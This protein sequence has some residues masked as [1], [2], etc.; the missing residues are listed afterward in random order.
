[1]ST[2]TILLWLDVHA[3][4][5]LSLFLVLFLRRPSLALPCLCLSLPIPLLGPALSL[6]MLLP[7]RREGYAMTAEESIQRLDG[8]HGEYT[9]V[10]RLMNTV[11]AS[12]ALTLSA[13]GDRRAYLL[14]LLRQREIEPL[15][16][17]LHRALH[18]AD[19]ESA[20][21]AASAI[22]ELQRL[23]YNAMEQAAKAYVPGPDGSWEAARRYGEAIA[24]YLENSEVGNLENVLSRRQYESVMVDLLQSHA[25]ACTGEDYA[26]MARFLLSERRFEEALAYTQAYVRAF[27]AQE[28]GYLLTLCIAYS[29]GDARLFGEV[30]ESLKASRAVLSPE[31]LASIR[32]WRPSAAGGAAL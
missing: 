6:V 25:A 12:D 10:D 11:P 29:I 15:R 31:A 1:M 13:E 9:G 5:T 24:L 26:A 18:N 30:L 4:L 21:Y 22:M 14:G 28:D 3:I 32:F 27:P 2:F 7:F 23:A 17:I 16:P 8:A 20:H 19:A